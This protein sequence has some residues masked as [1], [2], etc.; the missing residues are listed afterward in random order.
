MMSACSQL[1]TEEVA[2]VRH[3]ARDFKSSCQDTMAHGKQASKQYAQLMDKVQVKERVRSW[4]PELPV[5]PILAVAYNAS[6]ITTEFMAAMPREYV[7]KGAPYSS[8]L[9]SSTHPTNALTGEYFTQVHMG[10][11][12]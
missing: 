7:V 10:L 9:P 5:V 8:V 4:L 3:N 6:E 12:C 11:V 2:H 1:Q